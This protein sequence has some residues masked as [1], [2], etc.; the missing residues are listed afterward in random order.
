MTRGSGNLSCGEL[1]CLLLDVKAQDVEAYRAL[2]ERQGGARVEQV[3]EKLERE[4]S[5]AYRALE[6]LV[7]CDL[8]VKE[9][10][11]A[12]GGGYFSLYRPVTPRNVQ[13][14]VEKCLDEWY[15]EMRDAVER[16]EEGCLVEEPGRAKS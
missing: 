11:T 15:A 7:G 1:V 3:A 9:M 13:E 2:L 16:L 12:A 4:R 6:R 14:T 10:R 5:T 8:A